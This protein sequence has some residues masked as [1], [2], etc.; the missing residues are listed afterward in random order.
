MMGM[1]NCSEWDIGE[2]FFSIFFLIFPKKNQKSSGKNNPTLASFLVTRNIC[3]HCF[4]ST[5]STNPWFFQD[6]YTLYP[7]STASTVLEHRLRTLEFGND[8]EKQK[9]AFMRLGGNSAEDH[10]GKQ[11]HYGKSTGMILEWWFL[12]KFVMVYPKKLG[13]AHPCLRKICPNRLREPYRCRFSV[14][15]HLPLK[16]WWLPVEFQGGNG[17][18]F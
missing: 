18:F 3:F 6:L 13:K 8:D 17:F 16:S 4:V 11:M 14:A 9:V 1:I 7:T 5:A 10:L 12:N 15:E 2:P